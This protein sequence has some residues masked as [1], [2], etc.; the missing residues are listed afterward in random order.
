MQYS[1]SHLATTTLLPSQNGLRSDLRACN[2]KKKF[3]GGA[4]KSVDTDS[5]LCFVCMLLLY[6]TVLSLLFTFFALPLIN[7]DILN[8]VD[9]K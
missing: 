9:T 4:C 6:S 1:A 7:F 2:F 8:G 5:I 3:S